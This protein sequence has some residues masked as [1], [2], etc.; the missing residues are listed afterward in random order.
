MDTYNRYRHGSGVVVVFENVRDHTLHETVQS[1]GKS[2]F[3]AG[4]SR[5][6]DILD[7]RARNIW[8][9]IDAG[10]G[11]LDLVIVC[12]LKSCF[13]DDRRPPQEQIL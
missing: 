3:S 11:E 6:A 7:D 8:N 1:L 4:C 13:R 12:Q 5:I 9:E 2:G 10:E